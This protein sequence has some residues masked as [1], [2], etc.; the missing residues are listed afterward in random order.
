MIKFF[1]TIRYKLM[2]ENKTTKYFKYALGEII[3]VVIGILIA[4]QINNWNVYRLEVKEERKILTNLKVDFGN[5]KKLLDRAIE[6]TKDGMNGCLKMLEYTG[7]KERPKTSKDFDMILNN[8]FVS[9]FFRPVIGTLEEITNSGKLGIIENDELR[10][11][12]ATWP[13]IIEEV[14]LRYQSLDKYKQLLNQ[15]ILR[16]G[17]WLNADQV[18]SI[19]RNI[20][21][22]KSGF[23][24]DNRRLLTFRYFEN[25]TENMSIEYDNYLTKLNEA[26]VLLKRITELIELN[27]RHD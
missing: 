7:N 21:F 9:P 10:K 1:R 13:S 3:L 15:F 22:P 25:L 6:T 27:I 14:K 8:M 17:N 19:K 18:S 12:L 5:N 2:S 23:K 4:L 20:K 26:E 24:S 16:E 11:L